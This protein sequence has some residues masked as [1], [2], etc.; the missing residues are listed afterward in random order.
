MLRT[1]DK[2]KNKIVFNN[3][4]ENTYSFAAALFC[5]ARE[6]TTVSQTSEK[7]NEKCRD[8]LGHRWF[9]NL[10]CPSITQGHLRTNKRYFKSQV[11]K[12]QLHPGK[13]KVINI[14]PQ[15]VTI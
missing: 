8:Q 13:Q 6:A 5:L 15:V 14:K 2:C 9:L 10:N 1:I 3:L 4:T 11:Q 12:L 7:R